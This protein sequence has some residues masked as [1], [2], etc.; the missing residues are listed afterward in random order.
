MSV[1]VGERGMFDGKPCSVSAFMFG[2]LIAMYKWPKLNK[3][4]TAELVKYPN[5]KSWTEGMVARYYLE[6]EFKS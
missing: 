5:L 6:R 1:L 3:A 2:I 4:W